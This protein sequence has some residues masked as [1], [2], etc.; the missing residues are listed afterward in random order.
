[1]KKFSLS[2]LAAASMAVAG[3]AQADVIF[4]PDGTSVELSDSGSEQLALESESSI[5]TT[6]LGA[7]SSSLQSWTH[8]VSSGV[9]TG[10]CPQGNSMCLESQGMVTGFNDQGVSSEGSMVADSGLDTTV[11]GAGPAASSTLSTQQFVYVQ[12]NINWDRATAKSQVH[13]NA[14]LMNRHH[15]DR[16][17]GATFNSP[18]R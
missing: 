8:S 7:G 12:P 6:M 3:L 5:D 10:S 9:S 2:L 11:L 1:M 18:T 17:A 15:M 16:S 4:Y 13:S 14:H